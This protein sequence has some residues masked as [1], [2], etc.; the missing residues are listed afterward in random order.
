MF[1]EISTFI[2]YICLVIVRNYLAAC[3]HAYLVACKISMHAYLVG[4]EALDQISFW[5]SLCICIAFR[6]HVPTDPR[7]VWAA[8]VLVRLHR[9]IWVV[10]VRITDSFVLLLHVF[11]IVLEISYLKKTPISDRYQSIKVYFTLIKVKKYGRIIK[12]IWKH[13]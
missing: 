9:F 12:C 3:T 1:N 6:V 2:A 10:N 5:V 8:N 13:H 4:L 7:C 11:Q